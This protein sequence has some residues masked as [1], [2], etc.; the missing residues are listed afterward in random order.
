MS[1]RGAQ[2]CGRRAA[3]FVCFLAAMLAQSQA[4]ARDWVADNRSSSLSFVAWRAP[5]GA[6]RRETFRADFTVW[7]AQIRFDPETPENARLRV[8][9][10]IGSLNTGDGALNAEIAANG[11]FDAAQWPTAVYE[12]EGFD[13]LGLGRYRA[14]GALTLRGVSAPVSVEFVLALDGDR[15]EAIGVARVRRAD[16]G[17]GAHADARYAAPE[18]EANFIVRA[19]ALD[20]RRAAEPGAGPERAE[21]GD[22]GDRQ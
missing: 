4:L 7:S 13:Y 6:E 11:W 5:P 8:E 15:A 18:I 21:T 9:L 10:D 2:G 20:T 3:A 19:E 1:A 16:F 12:A 14:N 17:V 22:G